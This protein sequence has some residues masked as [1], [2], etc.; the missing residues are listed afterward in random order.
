MQ[1]HKLALLVPRGH[2]TMKAD[3]QLFSSKWNEPSQ[4]GVMYLFLSSAI[5]SISLMLYCSSQEQDT[6][7][8]HRPRWEVLLFNLHRPYI[9]T[10]PCLD[11]CSQ[12]LWTVSLSSA[13]TCS[14]PVLAGLSSLPS[15]SR[16][17]P[18]AAGG[19]IAHP[20]PLSPAGFVQGR[21]QLPRAGL[22]HNIS[23]RAHCLQ[24]VSTQVLSSAGG[25]YLSSTIVCFKIPTVSVSLFFSPAMF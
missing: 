9:K 19:L 14:L 5:S 17:S 23:S 3:W 8:Q 12:I 22:E 16:L 15:R 13:V 20:A 4:L 6:V 1:L 7:L 25:K 18:Q 11:C 2:K 24:A 21:R 10:P